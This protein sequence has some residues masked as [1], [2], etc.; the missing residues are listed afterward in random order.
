MIIKHASRNGTIQALV[1]A[2]TPDKALEH[3]ENGYSP[4]SEFTGE[5]NEYG[6]LTVHDKGKP[7]NTFGCEVILNAFVND[8]LSKNQALIA[9]Q[10]LYSARV[11]MRR[12]YKVEARIA[13]TASYYV[14]A[15]NMI[16]A[17]SAVIAGR[18][19]CGEGGLSTPHPLCTKDLRFDA[20]SES[21]LPVWLRDGLQDQ[22]DGCAC[23]ERHRDRLIWSDYG[24]TDFRCLTCGA[25]TYTK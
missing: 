4:I 12:W 19:I 1:V 20:M 22:G 5:G 15:H 21:E 16:D 2:E 3:F 7:M 13:P 25:V 18:A 11:K 23:G 14:Q 6:S 8:E 10:I 24:T 9:L 17:K